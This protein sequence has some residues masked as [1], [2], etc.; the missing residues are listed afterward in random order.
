MPKISLDLE[1]NTK[2]VEQGVKEAEGYI[3]D[4]KK[5]LRDEK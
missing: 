2:P 3:R 1:L 5:R 4:S